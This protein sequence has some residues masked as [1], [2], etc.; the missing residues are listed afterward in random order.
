MLPVADCLYDSS[1]N[2]PQEYY[3]KLKFSALTNLTGCP[4]IIVPVS[5]KCG[6]QI[7]AKEFDENKLFA[8]GEL[9]LLSSM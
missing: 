4:A 2:S 9:L 1:G 6:V 7:I 3:N 5:D 8:I